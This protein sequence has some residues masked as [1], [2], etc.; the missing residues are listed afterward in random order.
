MIFSGRGE[1]KARPKGE[2]KRMEYK[3]SQGKRNP[4]VT[5][6]LLVVIYLTYGIHVSFYHF[7]Y[8]RYEN[9]PGL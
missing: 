4:D 3:G 5:N 8:T 2:E 6:D 1:K 7:R 9:A